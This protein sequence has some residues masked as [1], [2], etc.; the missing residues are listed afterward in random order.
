MRVLPQAQEIIFE[1][2]KKKN[3]GNTATRKISFSTY[4]MHFYFYF[5][6]FGPLLFSNLLTFSTIVYF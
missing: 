3:N 4:K 2:Q 1:V 5:L 6:S